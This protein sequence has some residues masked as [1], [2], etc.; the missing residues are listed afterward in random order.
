MTE[1]QHQKKIQRD[2]DR[3]A[4]LKQEKEL[5]IL[6][7]KEKDVQVPDPAVRVPDAAS[8]YG[9]KPDCCDVPRLLKAILDELIDARRSRTAGPGGGV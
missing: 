1:E 4:R 8:L 7:D 2:R 3:R 6:L 5:L 9:I